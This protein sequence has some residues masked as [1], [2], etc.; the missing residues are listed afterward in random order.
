PIETYSFEGKTVLITGASSGIGLETA[1]LFYSLGANIAFICGRKTPPTK[2]PL[3]SPRTLRINLNLS[4][5]SALSAAFLATYEKFGRIDIVVPNAGLAEPPGQY[6]NLQEDGEGGLKPLDMIAVE[7][8]IKGT[9]Y[10]IA[11]GIHYLKKNQ[12]PTGGSIVIMSSMAGYEGVSGMPGYSASKHAATALLRSLPR[13]AAPLNIAV[14]L[15]APSMTYT[16]GAFPGTYKPGKAAFEEM[17]AKMKKVGVNMSSAYTCA[18]A[19]AYLVEK[20]LDANGVSLLV[21][22][23]QITDLES[24]IAA[25]R[26]AWF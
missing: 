20:G 8:D 1:E 12:N 7:I 15:V 17:D 10:T 14:S 4:D 2:I 22:R 18:N 25:S 24:E 23:D 16:P 3:E 19:V 5:W 13:N 11:L 21:D 6:F 26:P 9:M